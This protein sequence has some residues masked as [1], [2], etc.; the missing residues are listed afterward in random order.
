MGRGRVSV[1][2][3]IV[4]RCCAERCLLVLVR[5]LQARFS[6]LYFGCWGW[7]SAHYT[8]PLSAGFLLRFHQSGTQERAWK[9]WGREKGFAVSCLPVCSVCTTLVTALHPG[10]SSGFQS[11]AFWG[12]SQNQPHHIPPGPFLGSS[13]S[14]QAAPP[15][16]RSE[17]SSADLFLSLQ[18]WS[19][20]A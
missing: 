14:S 13:S 7:D 1:Q 16:Q 3:I 20:P 18:P 8:F 6:L 2:R 11:P 10:I 9:A 15:P 19:T 5:K 12:Q 17:F 4:S